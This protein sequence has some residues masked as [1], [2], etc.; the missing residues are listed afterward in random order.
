MPAT[1]PVNTRF[2]KTF[3]NRLYFGEHQVI[4]N[5]AGNQHDKHPYKSNSDE[6]ISGWLA[7][8]V[9]HDLSVS[10]QLENRSVYFDR[11]CRCNIFCCVG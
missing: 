10:I 7:R 1:G 11:L 9:R 3:L 2:G 5:G 8:T 6:G 4:Y